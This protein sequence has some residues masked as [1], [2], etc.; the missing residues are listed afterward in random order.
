ML[1]RVRESGGA[2][3]RFRVRAIHECVCVSECFWTEGSLYGLCGIVWHGTAMALGIWAF[4]VQSQE[5]RY[6]T[7][8]LSITAIV[9]V[10]VRGFIIPFQC[11]FHILVYACLLQNQLTRPSQLAN[12][13]FHPFPRKVTLQSPPCRV[14]FLPTLDIPTTILGQLLL[15]STLHRPNG[16]ALQCILLLIFACVLCVGLARGGVDLAGFWGAD[17]AS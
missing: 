2:I 12:P 8:L 16:V 5:H 17:L 1:D 13:L 10:L 3:Y 7:A 6:I 14:S 9:L 15:S 4:W 11:L